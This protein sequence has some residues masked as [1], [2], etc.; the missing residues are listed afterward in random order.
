LACLSKDLFVDA[1]K[2]R[3]LAGFWVERGWIRDVS[4]FAYTKRKCVGDFFREWGGFGCRGVYWFVNDIRWVSGIVGR[5]NANGNALLVSYRDFKLG[6][7]YESVKGFVPTDEEP[8]VVDEF[9][10]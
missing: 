2:R 6:V 5:P 1:A 4:N 9:K 3:R 7:S 10:G 8:R